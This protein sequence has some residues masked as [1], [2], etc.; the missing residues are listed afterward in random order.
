MSAFGSPTGA[1]SATEAHF[2][3]VRAVDLRNQIEQRGLAGAG[4][5]DEGEELAL[6]H[7]EA[8]ALDHPGRLVAPVARREAL[9]EIADLEQRAHVRAC[10]RV[11][12]AGRQR[13][14]RRSAASTLQLHAKHDA[15]GRHQRDEHAG[16]VEIHRAELD[17]IAEPAIGRDQF[18][19]HGAADRIRHGDAQSGEDV[20]NRAGKH[21]VARELAFARADDL[22]HLHEPGVERAHAGLRARNT[23]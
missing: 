13:N 2:A 19:D 17:Q 14:S 16:G 15:G 9:G 23:R 3:A 1:R 21:D 5:P 4:R 18:G 10:I 7:H 6:V 12:A 22:R 20:G 11:S 8:Q